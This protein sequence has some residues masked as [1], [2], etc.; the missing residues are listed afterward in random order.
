VAG[1]PT[2]GQDNEYV[3]REIMGVTDAE[4]DALVANGDIGT[5]YL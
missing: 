3:Y 2:A 4:W 5:D 1:R